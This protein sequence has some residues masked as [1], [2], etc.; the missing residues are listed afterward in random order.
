MNSRD[1]E[2]F[3]AGFRAGVI[4]EQEKRK[5]STHKQSRGVKRNLHIVPTDEPTARILNFPINEKTAS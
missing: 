4:A 2:I 1:A 5:A 3:R